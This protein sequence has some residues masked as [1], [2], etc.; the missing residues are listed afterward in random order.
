MNVKDTIRLAVYL[1]S[2][3]QTSVF[4]LM[5]D[6]FFNCFKYGLIGNSVRIDAA[7]IC[8]LKCPLCSQARDEGGIKKCYLKF[9]DFKK[10]VDDNPTIRNIEL[11]N[12]GEIFLNPELK[13][14]MEYAYKKRINLAA[15][16]GVNLN[17]VDEE[18]LDCLVKY[19]LRAMLISIDGATNDTYR[20]YRRG[21]D[22]CNVIENIKR[23]NFYKQKYNTVF[24]RLIWQFILF[25]HNEHE[26]PEARKMAKDLN[27]KFY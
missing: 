15:R 22:L 24:P 7:L 21:G 25:G 13:D 16:N 4:V 8:Q 6:F 27:M 20:I 9:A 18:T 17:T 19:K 11:S 26:L 2:E 12:D 5:K 1:F 3:R 23:I 10:F 14:I